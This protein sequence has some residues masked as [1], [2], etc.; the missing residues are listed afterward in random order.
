MPLTLI[1]V[2]DKPQQRALTTRSPQH[3]ESYTRRQQYRRCAKC[4][5]FDSRSPA[6]VPQE[7]PC[8]VPK[9]LRREAGPA[10]M[11]FPHRE[12]TMGFT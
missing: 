1:L 3:K 7:Q 2:D 9:E 12:A 5:G 6:Y 10:A 8:F 11:P 4:K